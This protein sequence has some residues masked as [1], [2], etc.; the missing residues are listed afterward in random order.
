MLHYSLRTLLI[1]L[2][3]GPPLVALA[4]WNRSE[5]GPVLDSPLGIIAALLVLAFFTL[6]LAHW[7][8][9]QIGLYR[10]RQKSKRR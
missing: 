8:G 7:I 1:L 9:F 4:W 5:L 10:A 2:A 6:P 3:I